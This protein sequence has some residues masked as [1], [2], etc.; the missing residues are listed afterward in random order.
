MSDS[1]THPAVNSVHGYQYDFPGTITNHG[2]FTLGIPPSV[3]CLTNVDSSSAASDKRTS[4]AVMIL[5]ANGTCWRNGRND[6]AG[7]VYG[8]WFGVKEDSHELRLFF[9][10]F[11][12]P[13]RV[14]G[15]NLTQSGNFTLSTLWLSLLTGLVLTTSVLYPT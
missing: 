15:S 4:V 1:S 6:T 5:V 13:G 2:R 12:Q 7:M 3:F 11:P 14:A 10:P 8:G 9:F